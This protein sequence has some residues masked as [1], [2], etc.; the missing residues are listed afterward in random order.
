MDISREDFE[1]ENGLEFG[2]E[3]I[4]DAGVEDTQDKVQLSFCNSLWSFNWK[5]EEM[6]E[7]MLNLSLKL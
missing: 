6:K 7:E 3:E 5:W 2:S 4:T 1:K